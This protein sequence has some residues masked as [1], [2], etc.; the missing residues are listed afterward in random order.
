MAKAVQKRIVPVEDAVK[1]ADAYRRGCEG[2]NLSARNYYEGIR[3]P[4]DRIL[5][6]A[7]NGSNEE[8]I[9]PGWE[10]PRAVAECRNLA[11]NDINVSGL[12]LTLENCV[13]GSNGGRVKFLTPDVEWNKKA[14]AVV[15]KRSRDCD[16][17]IPRQSLNA[18]LRALLREIKI[19]GDCVVVCDPV[20]TDG[21]LLTYEADQVCEIDSADWKAKA[22][23]GGWLEKIDGKPVPMIQRSGAV[24]D[25]LGRLHAIVCS[26]VRGRSKVSGKDATVFPVKSAR[27]VFQPT[28]LGQLRGNSPLLP[29]LTIVADFRDLVQSEVKSAKRGA[30]DTYQVKDDTLAAV[31]SALGAVLAPVSQAAGGVGTQIVSPVVPQRLENLE[32]GAGG[33]VI[34]TGK[35]TEINA[36]EF[37]RPSRSISDFENH[38]IARCGMALGLYRMFATGKVE[39]SMSSA[40][41]EMYLTW[42]GSITADQQMLKHGVVDFAVSVW[43]GMAKITPPD[44]LEIEDCFAV[45]WPA[46]PALDPGA[47]A[48]AK[49]DEIKY[50]F[51][52]FETTI[53][54]QW[55]DVFD[56]LKEQVEAARAA[57]IDGVLALF[58]TKAGAPMG[59]APAKA[60]PKKEEADT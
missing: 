19:G 31:Q 37:N 43:L 1:L 56:R 9:L 54:P 60:E 45:E 57:K 14:D 16:A 52:D 33:A 55:R 11:I 48:Q 2:V 40:R 46:P 36:L 20:L 50:G 35:E 58:E 32:Q 34:Y 27:I 30:Q 49:F 47:E 6:S 38:V 23:A 41:A 53:G 7:D 3:R 5:V 28:R 42:R 51:A 21:K 25:S 13:V 24:I 26:R 10:R 18:L 44:G 12:L 39:A 8:W 22:E 15:R 59:N 17:R 29:M 4:K